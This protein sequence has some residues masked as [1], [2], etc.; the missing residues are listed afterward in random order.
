M[1]N[2]FSLMKSHLFILALLLTFLVSYKIIA[3]INVKDLF[4]YVFF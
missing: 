4:G 3:K 1:Q 2:V